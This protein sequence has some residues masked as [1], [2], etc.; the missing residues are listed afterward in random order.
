MELTG[1]TRPNV[2]KEIRSNWNK[3]YAYYRR[4]FMRNPGSCDIMYNKLKKDVVDSGRKLA[5]FMNRIL[6]VVEMYGKPDE[7]NHVHKIFST[8]EDI[9]NDQNPQ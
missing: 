7:I 5:I 1:K 4:Y 8:V 2:K 6:K 3:E 9:N